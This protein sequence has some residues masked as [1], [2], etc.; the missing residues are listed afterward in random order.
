MVSNLVKVLTTVLHVMPVVRS[1][2]KMKWANVFVAIS[3]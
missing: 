2:Q 3:M 1:T